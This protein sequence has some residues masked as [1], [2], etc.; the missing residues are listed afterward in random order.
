[1]IEMSRRLARQLRAVLRK[2]VPLGGGRVPRPP[3]VL[4]AGPDG[5]R[6]RAHHSDIAVEHHQPGP[7]PADVLAVPG[8]TLDDFEGSRDTVV[9][10]EKVSEDA[11]QA[12]WEDAG[13]PQVRDYRALDV[14]NLPPFPELSGKLAPVEAGLLDALHEATRTAAREGVRFGV[15]RVQLRGGRGEVVGTDGRQL[16]IQ[17][18]FTLPWKEDLLVSAVAVFG[19]AELPRDAPVALGRTDTHV[20]VRVGP[21][22]FHLAIDRESHFPQVERA[23]PPLADGATLCRLSPDDA[24]FLVKALPRLPGRGDDHEP[25]TVDLDGRVAV[26]ARGEGQE[27]IT[28]LVLSRSEVTGPPMRFVSNR[29]YLLRAVR[30]GFTAREITKPAVPVVCRD[31]R[32]TFVWMP[33]NPETALPPSE[34]ALRIFST[35]EASPAPQPLPERRKALMTRPQN[36][37]PGNGTPTGPAPG[38]ESVPAREDGRPGGIGIGDLIAEAQALKEMLRDSY[39]RANRLLA[40]LKRHSKQAELLRSTL[41]SLR[42]LQGLG[43]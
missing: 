29:L 17:G 26:R 6:V 10:L 1:V 9:V 42:Q 37:G 31:E 27:R 13:L 15:Q 28:E 7:R 12:R 24:A 18:G 38:R 41:A 4:Q 3:L 25:V 32:R 23:I 2:A 22:T 16:L 19:C 8:A 36:T 35:G 33:L 14:A 20:C 34:D 21:W 43:G 40:A 39:E 30:L 11:V 5:L